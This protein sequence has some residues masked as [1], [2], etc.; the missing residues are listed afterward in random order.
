MCNVHCALCI[1]RGCKAMSNKTRRKKKPI[2]FWKYNWRLFMFFSDI[3]FLSFFSG[4]GVLFHSCLDGLYAVN[5]SNDIFIIIDYDFVWF[6]STD[7]PAWRPKQSTPSKR[8]TVA[9]CPARGSCTTT[10]GWWAAEAGTLPSCCGSWWRTRRD[11]WAPLGTHC[12]LLVNSGGHWPANEHHEP[13]GPIRS[14]WLVREMFTDN[15]RIFFNK[16]LVIRFFKGGIYNWGPAVESSFVTFL[17]CNYLFIEDS[18]S[19]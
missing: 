12:T 8:C 10:G 17:K 14:C 19:L 3:I 18:F 4:Y 1:H 16:R 9:K 13:V 15:R 5:F 2:K 6:M 11:C 7:T